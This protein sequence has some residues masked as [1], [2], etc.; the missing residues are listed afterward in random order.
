MANFSTNSGI[1]PTWQ[2]TEAHVELKM[3]C[4]NVL[5]ESESR[6][7][8]NF[9]VSNEF[10]HWKHNFTLKFIVV[11]ATNNILHS[12]SDKCSHVSSLPLLCFLVSMMSL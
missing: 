8:Y 9:H 1:R 11:S 2:Q 10:M 4:L 7:Y 5:A 6:Y 12:M 3:F